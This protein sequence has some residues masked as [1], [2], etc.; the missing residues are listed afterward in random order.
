MSGVDQRL[1]LDQQGSGAFLGDEHAGT[2][3]GLFMLRQ[4]QRR[5]VGHA[6]QAAVGHGEHAE[7]VDGAEAVLEGP[8]QAIGG[9]GV[10]L[11]VEH[12]VDHVLEHP[13]PGQ[14]ALLGDMTDHHDG[15]AQMLG[16]PGELRG[17]LA[18]L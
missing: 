9:V 8:H 14:C 10:A 2:G 17:A 16:K 5:R 4:K 1:D 11:E 18:H 7:L 12:A 13:R 6:A 3:H 15:A